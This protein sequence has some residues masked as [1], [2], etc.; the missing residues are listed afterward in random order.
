VLGLLTIEK[1]FR[2]RTVHMSS[3]VA[4]PSAG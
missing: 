1:P 2:E 4:I 3:R